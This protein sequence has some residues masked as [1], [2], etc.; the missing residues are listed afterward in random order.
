MIGWYFQGDGA[1][2]QSRLTHGLVQPFT[3]LYNGSWVFAALNQQ[4]REK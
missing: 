4:V 1:M 2:C 3:R